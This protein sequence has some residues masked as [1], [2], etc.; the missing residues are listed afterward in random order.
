[1]VS[2]PSLLYYNFVG[3]VPLNPSSVRISTSPPKRTKKLTPTGG[4]SPII[5]SARSALHRL[6]RGHRSPDPRVLLSLSPS[7]RAAVGPPSP[8]PALSHA[9]AR[10]SVLLSLPPVTLPPVPHPRPQHRA[11]PS[12]A[13]HACSSG[14]NAGVTSICPRPSSSNTQLW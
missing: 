7:H 10:L 9:L 13:S 5:R 3:V 8:T 2:K 4:T 6:R 12:L 1:V 14:S 11:T